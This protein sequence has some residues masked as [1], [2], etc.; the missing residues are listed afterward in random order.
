MVRTVAEYEVLW[1]RLPSTALRMP[2][3]PHTLVSARNSVRHTTDSVANVVLT[4][5]L[6]WRSANMLS[7]R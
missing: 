1:A 6:S 2:M 4:L 5:A 3:P 7:P